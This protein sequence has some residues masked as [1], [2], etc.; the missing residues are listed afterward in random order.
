MSISLG[1]AADTRVAGIGRRAAPDPTS[2]Q[3]SQDSDPNA[4]AAAS[5]VVTTGSAVA[6][7]KR[8]KG[9]R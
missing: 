1:A 3:V 9:W 5:G 7:P 4:A 6:A 8:A 2:V